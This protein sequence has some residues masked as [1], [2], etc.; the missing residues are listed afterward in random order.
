MPL[1]KD[2]FFRVMEDIS[3]AAMRGGRDFSAIK[4]VAVTKTVP[5]ALIEEAIEAGIKIFGENKVQEAEQKIPYIEGDA[6]WHMIGHLQTNKVKTAVQLFSTIHSVDSLRL[7]RKID[8]CAGEEGKKINI[9]LQV[10]LAGEET[11]FGFP[12]GEVRNVIP[13]IRELHHV[14]LQGLMIIPPFFTDPELSRP[15]FARLRELLFEINDKENLALR[16]LS[17][18]MSMD[19]PVAVEEGATLVRVGSAIFGQRRNQTDDL[20]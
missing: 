4:L 17:M 13:E 6:T 2:N 1:T 15:Y 11:K 20:R 18:G 8:H 14:N 7:A 3:E 16:E 12:E 10:D 9:L 19:F 5:S